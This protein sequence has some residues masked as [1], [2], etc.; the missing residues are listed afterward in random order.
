MLRI[1]MI[2]VFVWLFSL[3]HTFWALFVFL[4]AGATDFLDGFIA[5]RTGQITNFGKLMDPL[6]DKLMLITA[7][8]CL[9]TAGRVPLWI[10]L[11][12]VVKELLMLIGGIVML[13]RGVVVY[14]R[15]IG[16]AATA[17]FIVAVTA[18]FF[19]DQIMPYDEI[20]M[21]AAV[22]LSILA[23]VFYGKDML[24]HFTRGRARE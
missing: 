13:K 8:I 3:S 18:S 10:V 2:G 7:L 5:R 6:A 21:Y 24:T 17:L 11:A 15:L 20:L 22:V 16:K 14:A 1:A 12:I 19:H 23:M 9:M 4:L